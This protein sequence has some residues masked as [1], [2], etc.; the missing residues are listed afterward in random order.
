MLKLQSSQPVQIKMIC[1][2]LTQG[3]GQVLKLSQVLSKVNT[4][5]MADS[6]QSLFHD[7]GA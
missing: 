4:Q 5:N 7:S 2:I 1:K 3:C 6:N